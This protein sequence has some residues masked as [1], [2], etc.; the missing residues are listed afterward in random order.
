MIK[1]HTN[2]CAKSAPNSY[3][4]VINRPR[5][6]CGK[7]LDHIGECGEWINMTRAQ[8]EHAAKTGEFVVTVE[9]GFDE[10]EDDDS[11]NIR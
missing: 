11:S 5:N 1:K 4:M 3:P 6:V 8:H 2:L 10:D 9:E 7:K